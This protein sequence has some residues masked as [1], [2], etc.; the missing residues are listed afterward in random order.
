MHQNKRRSDQ[1]ETSQPA[2][3]PVR[4]DCEQDT[5]ATVDA[6]TKELVELLSSAAAGG[7]ALDVA[8]TMAQTVGRAQFSNPYAN[9]SIIWCASGETQE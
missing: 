8:M 5:E 2:I 1:H 7:A 6:M 4:M 9:S 3:R